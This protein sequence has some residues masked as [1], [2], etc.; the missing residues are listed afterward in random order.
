MYPEG[1]NKAVSGANYRT[2]YGQEEKK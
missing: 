2:V 1:K